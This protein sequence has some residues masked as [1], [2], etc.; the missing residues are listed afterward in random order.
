MS[1]TTRTLPLLLV[2]GVLAIAHCGGSSTSDENEDGSNTQAPVISNV[3]SSGITSSGATITWSTNEPAD[4][5]VE[6][7]L[8]TR[9]GSS[10]LL[11][12]SL[13]TV[14]SVRLSGLSVNNTYHYRV[15]SKDVAGN[16]AISGDTI[17]TPVPFPEGVQYLGND[18]A[19]DWDPGIPGG[20]PNYPVGNNV[21]DFGAT[22]DGIT[23]DTL[24]IRNAINAASVGTAVYLPEGNY[25]ITSKIRISKGIVVR[26]A[27]WDK[28]ILTCAF[29]TDSC[30]AIEYSYDPRDYTPLVSGY[31]KGSSV[32]TVQDISGF[33]A[34]QFVEFRQDNDPD[35]MSG[36]TEERTVG[37]FTR[38]AAV[39]PDAKTLTLEKPLHFQYNPAMNPGARHLTM[40]EKAGIEDLR[41]ELTNPSG[42]SYGNVAFIGVANSW[43]KGVWSHMAYG[44]HVWMKEAYANE[45]RGNV[46]Q[47]TW[48]RGGGGKGY[49][50]RS[51]SRS[52]DNLFTDNIYWKLRHSMIVAYGANGNVH[53]YSYS[54]DPAAG[55]YADQ[56]QINTTWFYPDSSTHGNY[57]YMNLWEGN[58]M[59]NA[60]ADNVHGTNSATTWFR[61][62]VTRESAF[63]DDDREVR[64][65]FIYVEENNYSHNI[66][67]NEVGLSGQQAIGYPSR[68]TVTNSGT[69]SVIIWTNLDGAATI[70]VHGNY[71]Y[72]NGGYRLSDT[73][74]GWE[75]SLGG[76][77]AGIPLSLYLKEAP[78][79][80]PGSY[81]WP[82]FGPENINSGNTIPA[83]TRFDQLRAAGK[84]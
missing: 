52:S 72:L 17:F 11:D 12:S 66:V 68:W 44:G 46:F 69:G 32:V 64:F 83:K 39:D 7:G 67:A 4:S 1:F 6:Y 22:G 70:R 60:L 42:S 71:E 38:V 43:M 80:W 25:R 57:P 34:G 76:E 9:Y 56:T 37:Q 55:D 47:D 48:E 2:A 61:N 51:E 40:V 27:G 31:D 50:I 41:I 23:D 49:G 78:S 29:S 30:L 65:P 62:K 19:I 21:T 13:V 79:W 16:L 24:A 73:N 77:N 59:Q 26:G 3:A 81:P 36:I 58:W 75:P 14:H 45:I 5:Q 28:T 84:I 63:V 54:A 8:T 53:S 15:K 35:L 33:V 20:I 18:R 74:N 82:P 10:T